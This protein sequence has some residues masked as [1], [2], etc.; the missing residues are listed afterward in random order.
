MSEEQ[1]M[2]PAVWVTCVITMAIAK[3]YT[4]K[5]C[6]VDLEPWLCRHFLP[7]RPVSCIWE[8]S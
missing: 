4:L 1:L 5:L 6:K 2:K 8:P 3:K 7:N